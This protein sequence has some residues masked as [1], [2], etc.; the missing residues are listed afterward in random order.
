M[1]ASPVSLPTLFNSV[2]RALAENQAALNQADDYNHNHGDNMVKNFKVIT[3]ALK[4]KPEAAP[5][6]QLAY[7]SQVLGQ[8]SQSGS[9]QLYAQGLAQAAR[10]L[11][12]QPNVNAQ[13]ALDLVQALLGGGASAGGTSPAASSGQLKG[14]SSLRPGGPTPPHAPTP[15][16]SGGDP[17]AQLMEGLLQQGGQGGQSSAGDPLAQIME[18]LLQQQG[19]QAPADDSAA[20][21][22][23]P[24]DLMAQLMEG[25]L[26][27]GGGAAPRAPERAPTRPTQGGDPL[28]DLIGAFLGGGAAAR[29]QAET[30][31]AGGGLDLGTLLS[32]GMAYMQAKQQGA[33]S[34]EALVQA[35][36]SGSQMNTT[37]SHA[38][39]GEIVAS[40][41]IN[42]L[43]KLLGGQSGRRR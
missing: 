10:K 24:N 11:E 32:A 1:P 37:Q 17:L 40:T 34:L 38:Q 2:T 33:S 6:E 30:P 13:N 21:P 8:K 23:N 29:P 14:P 27:S 42:T 12:G 18:G 28:S 7:A 31:Q 20:S 15:P 25:L 43:S 26:Q 5:S 16:Q 9:A 39:S 4:E 36:M 3:K 22:A 19:G 41:L 35:V